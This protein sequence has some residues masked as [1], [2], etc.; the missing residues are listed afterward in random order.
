M[1]NMSINIGGNL[2]NHQNI[3]AIEIKFQ[4]NFKRKHGV[5]QN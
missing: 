3:E 4:Y 5:L 2:T 1:N